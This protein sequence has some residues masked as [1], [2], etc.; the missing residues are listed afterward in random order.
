LLSGKILSPAS[1][2]KAYTP[3]LNHYGYG[4][5]INFIDGKKVVE[6]GGGITGF[7]SYI[8]RIPEDEICIIILDNQPNSANTIKMAQDIND[9][10]NG[11]DV[12]L[13]KARVAVTLDTALLRQYV[14]DYQIGPNAIFTMV[15]EDGHLYGQAKGLGKMELFAE[16][17]D[18]FFTKVPDGEIEFV[19][20]ADGKIEKLIVHSGHDIPG[21]RL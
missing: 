12:K 21:K 4:W 14:G 2:Q 10:L 1:Q 18:L 15:L 5:N 17:K 20:D 3:H 7:V 19:R 11:K 13:P 9:I 16:K 6:H 8:K